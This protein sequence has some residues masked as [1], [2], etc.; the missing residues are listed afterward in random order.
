VDDGVA[1]ISGAA[2]D[3]GIAIGPEDVPS[4]PYN[5]A[6]LLKLCFQPPS[7]AVVDDLFEYGVEAANVYASKQAAMQYQRQLKSESGEA[8][9]E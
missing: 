1:G 6:Q 4:F 3:G 5:L 2:G 8:F 7:D 9:A